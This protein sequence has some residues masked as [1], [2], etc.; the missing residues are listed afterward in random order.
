[1]TKTMI[2]G[3]VTLLIA[4]LVH[5]LQGAAGQ[6][7]LQRSRAALQARAVDLGPVNPQETR[8]NTDA[9]LVTPVDLGQLRPGETR[10]FRV[11]L[12][13]TSFRP[14]QLLPPESDCS[15]VYRDSNKP[16]TV[17]PQ[18]SIEIPFS[19]RAPAWP[20]EISKKISLVSADGAGG[21]WQAPVTARVVAKAW[22]VPPALELCYDQAPVL[23]PSVALYHDGETRIGAV[24]SSSS[25]ITVET[26]HRG[27]SLVQV[28]LTVRPPPMKG[29]ETWEQTVQVFEQDGAGELLR[30]PVRVSCPPELQCFPQQVLLDGKENAG[31]RLE[32]TVVL[33]VRSDVVSALDAAPLFPWVH[34]ESVERQ[35]RGFKVRLRFDQ[36]AMPVN[37]N[38]NI[39]RFLL[40]GKESAAYLRGMRKQ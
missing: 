26:E 6:C 17:P 7:R 14:L 16:F 33:V 12:R 28:D 11:L 34:V 30:I 21:R 4:L 20:G 29:G 31:A 9:L 13:N 18:G 10:A 3:G 39:I 1:M 36:T 32:R 40:K 8:R 24:V 37:L 27:E 22:A 23:E 35:S 19:L 38:E 25:A 15:C 5:L 2:W